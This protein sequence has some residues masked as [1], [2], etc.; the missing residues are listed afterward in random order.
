[1]LSEVS[2]YNLKKIRIFFI[3]RIFIVRVLIHRFHGVQFTEVL[4]IQILSTYT[5]C[6]RSGSVI[7]SLTIGST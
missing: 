7:L 5:V 2:K 6:V 1:M 3:S 4:S